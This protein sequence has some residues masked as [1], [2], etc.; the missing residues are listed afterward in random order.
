MHVRMDLFTSHLIP[1]L[2]LH[3]A[4]ALAVNAAF[5]SKDLDSFPGQ[6]TSNSLQKRAKHCPEYC[7]DCT[8]GYWLANQCTGFGSCWG[9]YCKNAGWDCFSPC[10]TSA[11]PAA[12]CSNTPLT[13]SG[14]VSGW[15][16]IYMIQYQKLNPNDPDL[17]DDDANYH[18]VIEIYDAAEPCPNLIGGP[19]NFTAYANKPHDIPSRLPDMLLVTAGSVDSDPISFE[20]DGDLWNTTLHLVNGVLVCDL[21]W[22]GGAEESA[23]GYQNGVRSGSCGFTIPSCGQD[24]CPS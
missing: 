10:S 14:Y 8:D 5:L 1:T 15:G 11:P 9:E 2:I 12:S 16:G 7:G 19:V 17:Q 3:L 23:D 20:Y 21:G 4:L 24:I 6:T 13:E 18:L 22:Y